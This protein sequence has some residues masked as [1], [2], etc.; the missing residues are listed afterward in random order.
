MKIRRTSSLIATGCTLCIAAASGTL[1]PHAAAAAIPPANPSVVARDVT[2][3]ASVDPLLLASLPLQNGIALANALINVFPT[4]LLAPANTVLTEFTTGQ[5]AKI[6]GTVQTGVQSEIASIAT[7]LNLPA[8]IV[9]TDLAAIG[10]LSNPATASTVQSNA[11]VSSTQTTTPQAASAPD[12][13]TILLGLASLPLQD[14]IAVTNALINVFPTGITAPANQIFTALTTGNTAAIPGII[15][16]GITA[17]LAAINALAQLPNTL[18]QKNIAYLES[19]F[20][21]TQTAVSRSAELASA[22]TVQVAPDPITGLLTLI[23]LPLQNRIAWDD[24]DNDVYPNG[25]LTPAT[26]VLTQLITG[27]ADKIPA[28][29]QDGF[30]KEL[31]AINRLLG[32]PATLVAHDIE[33]IQKVFGTTSAP[34]QSAV[35][36]PSVE[37]V[38][39]QK[40]IATGP[41][42]ELAADRKDQGAQ[43]DRTQQ[44]GD[45]QPGVDLSSHG[46]HAIERVQGLATTR[47][48]DSSSPDAGKKDEGKKDVGKTDVDKK[49]VDKADVDK[50]DADKK[51]VTGTERTKKDPAGTDHEKKGPSGGG[52]DQNSAGDSAGD[53][54]TKNGSDKTGPKHAK[55]GD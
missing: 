20:T 25:V 17:E 10:L 26:A 55:S 27:Q 7:L 18:V 28:T 19:L 48:R 50:T 49:D 2:L 8:Q 22:P 21:T 37:S 36:T 23:S 33:T 39:A 52:H 42:H 13:T 14:V 45:K 1:A 53:K 16:N 35:T 9:Q 11:L 44:D 24:A 12:P 38:V 15:Q 3:T 40:A 46:R 4:G 51:D 54:G 32:L 31:A 43:Q 6:P 30:T 29:I 34:Q 47:V 41:Q 5:V